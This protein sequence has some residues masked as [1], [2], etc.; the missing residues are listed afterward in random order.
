MEGAEGVDTFTYRLYSVRNNAVKEVPPPGKLT[1]N[2]EEPKHLPEAETPGGRVG[3]PGALETSGHG[4][5]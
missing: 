2:A 3:R 5:G 4:S 1:L